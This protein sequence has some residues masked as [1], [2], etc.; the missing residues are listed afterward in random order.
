MRFWKGPG[1]QWPG[2]GYKESP[3]VKKD[4]EKFEEAFEAGFEDDFEEEFEENDICTPG[5][6]DENVLLYREV[7]EEIIDSL[8]QYPNIIN[9]IDTIDNLK[10]DYKNK[11]II[12][13]IGTIMNFI[14]GLSTGGSCLAVGGDLITQSAYSLLMIFLNLQ[15]YKDLIDVISEYLPRIYNIERSI[16]DRMLPSMREIIARTD[17]PTYEQLDRLQVLEDR[18]TALHQPIPILTPF[19]NEIFQPTAHL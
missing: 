19:N 4:E 11:Q 5:E 9:W 10:Y 3:N 2:G 8:R 18:Y 6:R 14:K 17:N 12:R 15:T 16:V 13:K 1:Y 7:G